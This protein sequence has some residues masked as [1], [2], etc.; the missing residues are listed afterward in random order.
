MHHGP[1]RWVYLPYALILTCVLLLGAV[2]D[3]SPTDL[4]PYLVLISLF[5]IQ[6]V[7]PT[8]AGWVV[9]LVGWLVLWLA[10]LFFAIFLDYYGVL[11][12]LIIVALASASSVPLYLFR[13]RLNDPVPITIKAE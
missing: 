13:P 12:V 2:D 6:L 11:E 3:L 5:I 8:L 4:W 7:L 1:R 10:A 9:T